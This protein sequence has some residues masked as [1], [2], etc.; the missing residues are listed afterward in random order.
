MGVESLSIGNLQHPGTTWGEE[1]YTDPAQAADDAHASWLIRVPNVRDSWITGVHSRQAAAHTSTCHML[2]NGISL[3]SSF[4][5][6]V[7][8]CAMRRPHYGGGGNGLMYRLQH[9]HECLVK[10]SVA[11]FSRHGFVISH[12]GTS[13][14]VFLLCEDRETQRATGFSGSYNTGGSGSDN[15]MHFSHSNL[16]D[17]CHA[18]NSF[19]TA[20]N[21]TFSGTV[22]HGLTSAHAVY[23]NT[24]AT[25]RAFTVSR[26]GSYTI[27]AAGLFAGETISGTT[28]LEVLPPAA[29]GRCIDISPVADSH[30]QDGQV[31]LQIQLNAR[32]PEAMPRFY[33]INVRHR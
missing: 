33:R 5:I 28:T 23:W 27:G 9:S 7:R 10:N 15:H 19:Y 21:R 12:A 17:R 20:H 4:R 31:A 11:D 22:P 18:H 14:N 16:W 1:D 30:V 2:C 8:D 32:P 26:P 6:T 3:L 13:G 29:A 25:G 24:T